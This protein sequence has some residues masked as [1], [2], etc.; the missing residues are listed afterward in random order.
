MKII[1]YGYFTEKVHKHEDTFEYN[2]ISLQ[3]LYENLRNKYKFDVEIDDIMFSVNGVYI[4]DMNFKIYL[5]DTV[6]LLPPMSGG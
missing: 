2:N 5:Y 6:C 4:G 1:Y 3:D